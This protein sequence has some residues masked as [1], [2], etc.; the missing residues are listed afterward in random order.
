MLTR[1]GPITDERDVVSILHKIDPT[2]DGAEAVT[3][4]G[5]ALGD[6][7]KQGVHHCVD[8]DDRQ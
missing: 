3:Q 8:N 7:V 6:S 5:A 4:M 1:R 2:G